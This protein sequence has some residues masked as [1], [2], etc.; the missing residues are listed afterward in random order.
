AAD[1]SCLSRST[2]GVRL[3]RVA[4]GG[5][6]VGVSRTAPEEEEAMEAEEGEGGAGEPEGE[7]NE[8]E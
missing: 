4:E 2:Q 5:K 1:I 6:V 7:P 3:M 8:T